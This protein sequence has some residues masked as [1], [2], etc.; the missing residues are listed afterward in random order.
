MGIISK[1][2]GSYSDREVKRIKPIIDKI[3]KLGPEV[4]VLSD[5]ELRA[6][7]DEFK[8]R[9]Q[10]NGESLEHILPEAFAVVREAA[11]RSIG[12]KHYR[13]QLAWQIKQPS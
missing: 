1:V 6:K 12:L 3:E 13:E 4:E 2:F 8:K 5:E 10:E 9:V 7:T 11:W